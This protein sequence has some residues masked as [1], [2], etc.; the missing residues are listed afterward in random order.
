[1]ITWMAYAALVGALIAAGAFAVER[2]AVSQGKPRRFVWLA[3]L[4]LA[5][6]VPLVGG[7]REPSSTEAPAQAPPS[8]PAAV[9]TATVEGIPGFIPSLPL[10]ASRISA[11]AA[12][13]VWVAGSTA[14]LAVL[15][16]VLVAVAWAR[17][18]WPR[19]RV[20]GTEVYLSR[21]FGPA[22]VGIV[23]PK[24]VIPAW[25]LRAKPSLRAAILRHEL[26]H[27]R[28][29]DHLALL[30][31]A[32]VAV[33]FPWNPAI[34]WMCRRLRA[35][36]EIDCDQ[37]VVASGIATA[38]YGSVLLQ[39]WTRSHGRWGLVPAMGQPKS[40]LER[41]LKTMMEERLRLNAAHGALLAAT[42]LVTL[43][44]A[45]EVPAPTRLDEALDQVL[46]DGQESPNSEV[47]ARLADPYQRIADAFHRGHP[48]GTP[49]PIV[50]VD[51]QRLSGPAG[52]PGPTDAGLRTAGLPTGPVSIMRVEVLKHSAAQRLL[53]EEAP[54]GVVRIFTADSGPVTTT[55][56]NWWSNP[57]GSP[58]NAQPAG[59]G[60]ERLLAEVEEKGA[61]PGVLTWFYSVTGYE[62]PEYELAI[63]SGRR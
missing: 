14:A 58:N 59:L 49:P 33:V 37:R 7:K 3:A 19:V 5:I 28:T 32:I 30:Y 22:L 12:G 62:S 40:L 57:T 18:R 10:P 21:R 52:A 47:T 8:E 39:V 45:C 24:P 50:F 54:G 1:M 15:C 53:G 4:A 41:R 17:R 48:A 29:R 36:I 42:A 34:W 25:V 60:I 9:G 46:A 13:I 35:A 38:D 27:A 26:E 6:V 2:L 23:A 63:L 44:I 51:G 11:Q 55:L 43:G 16:S 61:N 56:A 31:A 20:G